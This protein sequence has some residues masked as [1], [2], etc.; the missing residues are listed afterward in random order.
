MLVDALETGVA[1][2]LEA[3]RDKRDDEGHAFGGSQRQGPH[4]EDDARGRDDPGER[5]ARER[6][7]DRSP[8]RAAPLHEPPP[9][10]VHASLPED[11]EGAAR[12]LSARPL[13][14]RLPQ[15]AGGV[16]RGRCR[17]IV[18]A[19]GDGALGFWEAVRDV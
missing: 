4:P 7:A 1:A 5:A 19:V 10:A 13:H 17:R 11:G 18:R 3:H 8:W 6:P 12:A 15:G 2:Y 16:A 14:G 9:A